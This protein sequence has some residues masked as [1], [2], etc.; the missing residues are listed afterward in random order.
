MKNWTDRQGVWVETDLGVGIRMIEA[1]KLGSAEVMVPWVHLVGA[2]GAT[3]AALPESSVG[4][5]RIA[6]KSSIP[7]CRVEGISDERLAQL[8][9]V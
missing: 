8:G 1:T 9:Y 4:N 2:D 6:R 7:T 3:L 5:V